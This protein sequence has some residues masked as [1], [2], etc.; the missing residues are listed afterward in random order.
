MEDEGDYEVKGKTPKALVT[1]LQYA[2][3]LPTQEIETA[4]EQLPEFDDK[5]IEELRAQLGSM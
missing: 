2:Y 4:Q 3:T 1:G 5:S